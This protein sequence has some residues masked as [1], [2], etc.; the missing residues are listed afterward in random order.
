MYDRN[1]HVRTS[2][3]RSVFTCAQLQDAYLRPHSDSKPQ[4]AAAQPRDPV[5]QDVGTV[6]K[7]TTNTTDWEQED[8]V[9]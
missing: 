7:A 9:V 4:A 3:S 8:A 6:E 5:T 2:H 1:Y